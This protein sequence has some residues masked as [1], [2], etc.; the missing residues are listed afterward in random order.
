MKSPEQI[1]NSLVKEFDKL[2]EI[3]EQSLKLSREIIKS[4]SKSIRNVHRNDLAEARTH[5][6]E[7]NNNYKK[8]IN[9]DQAN[10]SSQSMERAANLGGKAINIA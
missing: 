9:C 7:A 3:R 6:D 2:N 5:L 4:C 10:D 8:F 1:T